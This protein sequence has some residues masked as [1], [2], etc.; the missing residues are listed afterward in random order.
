MFKILQQKVAEERHQ[1]NAVDAEKVTLA[2]KG[3]K[4]SMDNCKA[5]PKAKDL[6][7]P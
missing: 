6:T 3:A 7:I 1:Y 2:S 5:P 4:L